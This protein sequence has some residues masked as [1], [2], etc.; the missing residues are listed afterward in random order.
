MGRSVSTISQYAYCFCFQHFWF[1]NFMIY[2]HLRWHVTL[3]EPKC[4]NTT[5]RT[6]SSR[7]FPSPDFC[8]QYPSYPSYFFRSSKFDIW[9]LTFFSVLLNMGLHCTWRKNF[10]NATPTNCNQ[11]FSRFPFSDVWIIDFMKYIKLWNFNLGVNRKTWNVEC[12][13]NGWSYIFHARSFEFDLGSFRTCCKILD[14]KFFKRLLLPH[15]SLC[16]NQTL[17]KVWWSGGM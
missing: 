6:N 14:V 2:F 7:I 16:S 13:K 4:Q 3:W 9:I 15:F 5:P 1:S 17:W 10:Q 12:L 8:I 11:I